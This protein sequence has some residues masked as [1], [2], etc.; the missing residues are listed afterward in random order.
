[1]SAPLQTVKKASQSSRPAGR[2]S[3][4]IH[5]SRRHVRR[6]KYFA[7]RECVR[8]RL[9]TRTRGSERN[10]FCQKRA[11]PFFDKLKRSGRCPLLLLQ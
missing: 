5:F 8:G 11:A 2:E 10:P 7:R 9:R 1:M 3:C 6:E 4:S